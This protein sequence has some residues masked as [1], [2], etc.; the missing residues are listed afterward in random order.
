MSIDRETAKWLGSIN[1]VLFRKLAAAKL[2]EPRVPVAKPRQWMLAEFIDSYMAGRTDIKPGTRVNLLRCRKYLLDYFGAGR[3]LA[4]I[5]LGDADEFRRWLMQPKP[6]MDE[7]TGRKTGEKQ[8]HENTV[9]RWCG[10]AKQFFRAAVRKRL[11]MRKPVRRYAGH[12]RSS[13]QDA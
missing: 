1:D 6:V 3:L 9:R 2:V 12:Q 4:E 13:E 7:K 11:I 10:R 5:S 8:L